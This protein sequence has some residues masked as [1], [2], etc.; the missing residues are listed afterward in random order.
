MKKILLAFFSF[1][2]SNINAQ[3]DSA[4]L[5]KSVEITSTRLNHFAVGQTQMDFDSATLTHF[6]NQSVADLI[7]QNTPLSIKSYGA[8]LATI[9]TRGT[10]AGQT[11]FLWNGFDIRPSMSGGVDLS[12]LPN[13]FERMN[14]KNG[15]NSALLGGGAMGGAI[16]FDNEIK[17][18]VGFHGRLNLSNG[19]FGFGGQNADLSFGT[20]RIAASLSFQRQKSDNDFTFLNVAEIGQPVQKQA[21]AAFEKTAILGSFFAQINEKQVLKTNVWWQNADHQIPNT[22]TSRNDNARQNDQ[23]KRISTEWQRI[24]NQRVTKIRAAYFDESFL[25]LSDVIDSS[26]NRMKNVI[27]EA[28]HNVDFDKWGSLRVGVNTTQQMVESNNFEGVKDRSR[29]AIFGSQRLNFKTIKLSLNVRQEMSDGQL[30]PFTF[31]LGVENRLSE[32]F[33]LR[34]SFSRNYNLPTLND[35]HWNRL[36][37]VNLRAENGFSEEIG[38]DFTKEKTLVGL[39]LFNLNVQDWIQWSPQN[40]GLWRPKNLKKVWSRGLEMKAQTE[41]SI[42]KMNVKTRIS[43]QLSRATDDIS[44]ENQLLYVPIHSVNG[45]VLATFKQFSF[46]WLQNFSTDRPM[47]S[48][49]TAFTKGFGLSNIQ[50]YLNQKL[51]KLGLNVGFK[52]QNL[53]NADYQ[54]I[55]YYA[56]PKR[57]ILV[58]VGLRF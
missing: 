56:S 18:K 44:P 9:S 45:S 58:E 29:F 4:W 11:A 54:T 3:T 35:L 41:F 40:D 2:F 53:W 7:V 10:G 5:L 13:I 57:N 6:Q 32:C 8:G 20:G 25:Y 43:Y 21:N 38:L 15:G 42:Q 55:Q 48:D 16:Y 37:N 49:G 39:T 52:I 30:I 31:S 14:I 51:G 46:Q 17:Q 33:L 22:M 34:G 36:G 47:T 23:A 28:E 1:L 19:S 12:I 27:V 50:F 24:D 26:K